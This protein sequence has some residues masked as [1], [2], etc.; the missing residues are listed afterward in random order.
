MR[1]MMSFPCEGCQKPTSKSSSDDDWICQECFV[2]TNQEPPLIYV[3]FRIFGTR[4]TPSPETITQQ[5]GVDPTNSQHEKDVLIWEYALPEQRTFDVDKLLFGLKVLDS[6][7]VK[8]ILDAN[9]LLSEVSVVAYVTN[10]YP[11]LN[12][13]APLLER[14]TNLRATLDIDIIRTAQS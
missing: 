8:A 13:T 1:A 14:I 12:F 6:E 10:R 4:E 7:K 5:L 11:A 3:F 9:N 2:A